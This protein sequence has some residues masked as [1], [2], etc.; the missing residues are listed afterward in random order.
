M[1]MERDRSDAALGRGDERYCGIG[2]GFGE[3]FLA[4][5]RTLLFA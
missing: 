3:K 1:N 5:C 4:V 2:I